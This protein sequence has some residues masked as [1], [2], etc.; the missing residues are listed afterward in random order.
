MGWP[1]DL[2]R[3]RG[4]ARPR[5]RSGARP[6]YPVLIEHAAAIAACVRFQTMDWLVTALECKLQIVRD[7]DALLRIN[8]R[9]RPYDEKLARNSV[10]TIRLSKRWLEKIKHYGLRPKAWSKDGQ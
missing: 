2:A 4:V 1:N 9:M 5:A 8:G 10:M 3:A 7:D 6:R